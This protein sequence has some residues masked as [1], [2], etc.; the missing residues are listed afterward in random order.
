MPNNQVMFPKLYGHWAESLPT[1]PIRPKE[2]L[3]PRIGPQENLGKIGQTLCPLGLFDILSR[4]FVHEKH[5][6]EGIYYWAKMLPKN[7]AHQESFIFWG[8]LS[9]NAF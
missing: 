1:G 3:G 5:R 6:I 8:N 7:F 9:T 4:Q 2:F